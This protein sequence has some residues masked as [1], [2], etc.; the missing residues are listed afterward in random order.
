VLRLAP[1]FPRT[2]SS[3]CV[4]FQTSSSNLATIR[5]LDCD[6]VHAGELS[7]M[8]GRT[9]EPSSHL[10]PHMADRACFPPGLRQGPELAKFRQPVETT[11]IPCRHGLRLETRQ[12]RPREQ[13]VDTARFSVHGLLKPCTSTPKSTTPSFL[14]SRVQSNLQLPYVVA[15]FRRRHSLLLVPSQPQ[16]QS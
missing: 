9:S 12:S 10:F 15:P 3:G 13:S 8:G 5:N 4:V 14:I 11:Q 7:Q 2:R 1:S 6:C 16:V